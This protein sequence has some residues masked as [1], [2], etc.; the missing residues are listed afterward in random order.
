MSTYNKI[1]FIKGGQL[2][3]MILQQTA[4]F[5][6]KSYVLDDD[7]ACPAREL[8]D[9]FSL[10][11]SSDFDDVYRFGKKLDLLTF[12]YEHINIEAL[13]KLQSEGLPVYPDPKIL[14][15]VQDKGLQ[16][17]FYKDHDIPTSEF[18]LVAG[19]PDLATCTNLL[20]AV[21]K[22][23]RAGYDGRGVHRLDT[24]GDY[25]T[26]FNEP[27]IVERRVDFEKEISVLLARN[28]KGET[29]VYPT[30]EMLFHPIKNL[31]EFLLSPAN[32]PKDVDAQ[33]RRIALQ[34]AGTLGVVGVLAVEMFVT[35]EG[36]VLVN[37]IAVRVHNSG[38]HT[39][40]ANCTSQFEQHMRAVLGMPLGPTDAT[41]AAVMVNILGGEGFEGPAKY[42]GIPEAI[43]MGGVYVHLYGKAITR[44]FRKMGHATVVDANANEALR[45]ARQVKDLIKVKA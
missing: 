10:G 35:K 21:Q 40:E 24:A 23:R 4:G 28:A 6:I 17:N 38:H 19:R 41:S 3:R 33:A 14:E 12:E 25:A 32:I 2:A 18:R 26:A 43:G 37:E 1:G 44:P 5:G 7:P 15:I 29:A 39:I 45:K 27:S 30:V 8:C 22:T 42:E 9:D 31:V 11:E 13:K 20:P 34:I 36:A 16:K